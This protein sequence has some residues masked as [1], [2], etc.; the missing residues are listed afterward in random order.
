[1]N[2]GRV[3]GALRVIAIGFVLLA[4][5]TLVLMIQMAT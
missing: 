1:M 5:F 3:A 4:L 2:R